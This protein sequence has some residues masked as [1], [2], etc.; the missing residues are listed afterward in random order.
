[1]QFTFSWRRQVICIGDRNKQFIRGVISG[2][3]SALNRSQRKARE[4]GGWRVVEAEGPEKPSSEEAADDV[5]SEASEGGT[6][7]I[8]GPHLAKRNELGWNSSWLCRFKTGRSWGAS[9]GLTSP[10]GSMDC[11]RCCRPVF[12]SPLWLKL[13]D[14]SWSC[15]SLCLWCFS[16]FFFSL[17]F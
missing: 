7:L 14:S 17:S 2:R 1:M 10:P 5:N 13:S 3:G 4:M 8:L 16:F 6:G 15:L 12:A 9:S 11:G